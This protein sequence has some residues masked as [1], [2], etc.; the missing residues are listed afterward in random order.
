MSA[1]HDQSLRDRIT[2]IALGTLDDLADEA[3]APRLLEVQRGVVARR[4]VPAVV[5]VVDEHGADSVEGRCALLY[6]MAR[7]SCECGAGHRFEE[8]WHSDLGPR[9]AALIRPAES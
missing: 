2:T 1:H 4:V 5:S 8:S 6:V 9:L 3:G 7:R